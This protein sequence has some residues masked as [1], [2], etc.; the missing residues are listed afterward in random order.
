MILAFLFELLYHELAWAYD[1]VSWLVSGGR[2]RDWQ[3]A[4]LPHLVGRRVLEVGCG[5]GHLLNELCSL[6][7]EV[8]GIDR[9]P[10]M[11]RRATAR[12][13]R[14]GRSG[15]VAGADA[16]CLPF[17]DASFDSL[18]CTFPTAV[19]REAEFWREAVRVVRSGGRIIIGEGATSNTRLWPGVFERLWG[20]LGGNNSDDHQ[21]GDTPLLIP[22]TGSSVELVAQRVVTC[23]PRG[24]VHLIVARVD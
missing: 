11:W 10:A 14:S 20:R 5:P 19:V 8:I 13:A 12:L 3:R 4:A 2:W 15:R 9:S 24:T 18:L 16:R 23:T 7:Y 17:A 21:P 6:G 1:P 22:A